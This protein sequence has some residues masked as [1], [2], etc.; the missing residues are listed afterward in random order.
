ML[1]SMAGDKASSP[2]SFTMTFF[3][4]CSEVIKGDDIMG[5]FQQFHENGRLKKALMHLH[6]S[7]SLQTMGGPGG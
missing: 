5:V 6:C 4:S 3:Q 2:D 7:C 1:K